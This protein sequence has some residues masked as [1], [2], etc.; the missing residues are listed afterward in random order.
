MKSC[1][2]LENTRSKK[3]PPKSPALIGLW[4]SEVFYEK[5]VLKNFAKLTGK[6]LHQ[7]LLFNKAAGSPYNFIK[8]VTLAQLFS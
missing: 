1:S 7:D 6:H 2:V 4:F 5:D 3:I 8:K